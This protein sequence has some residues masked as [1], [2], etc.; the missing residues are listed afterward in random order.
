MNQF[1]QFDLDSCA[2]RRSLEFQAA[3]ERLAQRMRMGRNSPVIHP[4]A[5]EPDD[6]EPT[7][8]AA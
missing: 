7:E 6:D 8:P 4:D 1:D 2:E 3:Q 5:R